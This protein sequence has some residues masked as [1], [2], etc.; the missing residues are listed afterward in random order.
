MVSY[1][2]CLGCFMKVHI[3]FNAFNEGTR[4]QS[5]IYKT[6]KLFEPELC[7]RIS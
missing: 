4:F 7:I 2:D 5:A 3:S 6:Q 1:S